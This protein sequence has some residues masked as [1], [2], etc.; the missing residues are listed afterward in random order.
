[1]TKAAIRNVRYRARKKATEHSI[2]NEYN[3][4]RGL[5]SVSLILPKPSLKGSKRKLYNPPGHEMKNMT[6]EQLSVWRFN[7][8]KKRNALK[9]RERRAKKAAL[10]KRI[11]N[12]V[13]ENKQNEI[14]ETVEPVIKAKIISDQSV[15]SFNPYG[16]DFDA[17]DAFMEKVL[18]KPDEIHGA[19]E[20]ES[21]RHGLPL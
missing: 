21:L 16:I 19:T 11:K 14:S 20:S 12:A 2:I 9:M 13:E 15:E 1:M 4:I 7:E 6:K 3:Q 18:N 10:M 8:K 17:I 5:P